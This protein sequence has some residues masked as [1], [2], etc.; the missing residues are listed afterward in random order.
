VITDHSALKWLFTLKVPNSKLLRWAM[1]VLEYDAVIQH[2]AGK[3]HGNAHMLS[4][5]G[6]QGEQER[7]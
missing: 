7:H 3:L 2:R 5:L 6:V 1:R 4:R